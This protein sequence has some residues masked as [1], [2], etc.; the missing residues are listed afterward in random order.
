MAQR[1]LLNSYPFTTFLDRVHYLIGNGDVPHSGTLTSLAPRDLSWRQ[2]FHGWTR[3]STPI[4]KTTSDP[5]GQKA[6]VVLYKTSNRGRI[7]PE[8]K[9]SVQELLSTLHSSKGN[10]SEHVVDDFWQ[11]ER[12]QRSSALFGTVLH[13]V[14]RN[15]EEHLPHLLQ[16]TSNIMSTFSTTLPS[17]TNMLRYAT[18][19]SEANVETMT[20]RFLPNLLATNPATKRPLGPE[21]LAAFPP[22]EMH[23]DIHYDQ[24]LK[25]RSV[26]AIVQETWSDLML[27]AHPVDIRFLQ[28]SVQRLI[29][30]KHDMPEITNFMKD[31]YMTRTARRLDIPP[32]IKFPISRSLTVGKETSLTYLGLD[33]N[34]AFHE[35]EYLFTERELRSSL[36]LSIDDWN[37]D[38]THISGGKSSGKRNELSVK[39]LKGSVE[40]TPVELYEAA[41]GFAESF[42]ANTIVPSRQ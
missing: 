5:V 30:E 38:Y 10:S 26:E 42:G 1:L 36:S 33:N 17:M 2:K 14:P 9:T 27:P 28:Q 41:L 25:L 21:V 13:S 3:W 23:F 20:I 6:E 32:T 8:T 12:Q 35:V 18:P 39:P 7:V 24:P 15:G 16:G 29:P 34:Q 31:S 19:K 11:S 4:G 40:V 22:I 37:L